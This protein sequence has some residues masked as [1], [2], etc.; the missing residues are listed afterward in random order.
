MLSALV[1]L[2]MGQCFPTWRI[3]PSPWRGCTVHMPAAWDCGSAWPLHW[4]LRSGH[5]LSR[6]QDD[7]RTNDAYLSQVFAFLLRQCDDVCGALEGHEPK[8]QAEFAQSCFDTYLALLFDLLVGSSR[9]IARAA[10]VISHVLT[11]TAWRANPIP[12]SPC[13]AIHVCADISLG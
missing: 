13:I 2:R 10:Q 12:V 11:D 5:G 8:E 6:I 3:R 4:V 1:L 9:N 7:Y